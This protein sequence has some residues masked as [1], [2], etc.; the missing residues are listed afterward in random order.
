MNIFLITICVYVNLKI[1][2]ITNLTNIQ[3][4]NVN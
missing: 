1:L 4:I 2:I 3:L